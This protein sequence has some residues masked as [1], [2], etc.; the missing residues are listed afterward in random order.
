MTKVTKFLFLNQMAGPLFREL[1]EDLSL[2]MPKISKLFPVINFDLLIGLPRQ[3][4]KT[5]QNTIQE[6][7]VCIK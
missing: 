1:A 7:R 6:F 5:I 4:T 3:T 2:K